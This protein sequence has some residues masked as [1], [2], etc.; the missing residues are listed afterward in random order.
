[1]N[2]FLTY[3]IVIIAVASATKEQNLGRGKWGRSNDTKVLIA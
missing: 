1:M 2:Y 3:Y